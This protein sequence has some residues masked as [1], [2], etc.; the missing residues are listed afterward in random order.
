MNLEVQVHRSPFGVSGVPHEPD[1]L[2]GLDMGPVH[3]RRR[4]GGKVCVVELIALGIDDPEPVPA[5]LVP[6]DGEDRPVGAS[7]ERLA[8]LAEDVVAVVIADV[9]ARRSEGVDVR[10]RAVHREDV[11]PGGQLRMDAV[12]RARS[13]RTDTAL[14]VLLRA[15]ARQV[16]DGS[17]IRA[18]R[19]LSGT[20]A[21]G[22]VDATRVV[23]PD[24]AGGADLAEAAA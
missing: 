22:A 8:E 21:A 2:A 15:L 5:D 20:G 7:N 10:A 6:A 23:V 16:A 11:V 24:G 19:D 4:E 17:D 13:D 1:D 12:Q 14:L 9:T 3:G 18:D